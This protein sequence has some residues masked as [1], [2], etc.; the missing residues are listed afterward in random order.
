[1]ILAANGEDKNSRKQ[2][3]QG[4][5]KNISFFSAFVNFPANMSYTPTLGSKQVYTISST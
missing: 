5:K 1:M 3:K 2:L 4:S